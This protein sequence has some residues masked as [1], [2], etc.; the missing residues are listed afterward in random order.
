MSWLTSICW[1]FTDNGHENIKQRKQ[2]HLFV[3]FAMIEDL[4]DIWRPLD[5]VYINWFNLLQQSLND[6][7]Y[8][9]NEKIYSI[10]MFSNIYCNNCLKFTIKGWLWT[11]K[12]NKLGLS[13][14]TNWVSCLAKLPTTYCDSSTIV[15]KGSLHEKKTEIVWVF[16]Y[17]SV[18]FPFFFLSL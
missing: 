14:P 2:L 3:I 18:L 15:A 12:R 1:C 17:I 13:V 11:I 9:N 6:S 16:W 8:V 4:L 10:T 7:T 5:L